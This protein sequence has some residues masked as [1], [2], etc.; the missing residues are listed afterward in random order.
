[1]KILIDRK[2]SRLYILIH[3]FC[4]IKFVSELPYIAP[5]CP[6]YCVELVKKTGYE[7]KNEKEKRIATKHKLLLTTI[8]RKQASIVTF[9]KVIHVFSNLYIHNYIHS[10]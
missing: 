6:I 9:L 4:N 7:R 8:M 10:H 3:N 2:T 1:M 5:Y